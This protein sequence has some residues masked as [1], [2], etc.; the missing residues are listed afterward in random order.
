MQRHSIGVAL[1]AAALSVGMMGCQSTPTQASASEYVDDAGLTARVKSALL[2]DP[3]VSGLAI[4]VETF[5]GRVQLS[6]FAN[7]EAE[8]KRAHEVAHGVDGATTVINDILLK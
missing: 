3:K 5:K 7:N 1:V 4:N 8:R 6:G 2:A